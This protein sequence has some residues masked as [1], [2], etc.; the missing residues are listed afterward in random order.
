MNPYDVDILIESKEV[1]DHKELLKMKLN[2]SFLKVTSKMDSDEII[3][4]TKLHKSDL[5]RLRAMNLSR[6]SIDRLIGLLDSLGFTT[7]VKVQPKKVS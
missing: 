2:A 3:S 5:S 7:Q 1:L 6:F 4:K